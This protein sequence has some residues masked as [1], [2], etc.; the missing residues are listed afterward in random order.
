MAEYIEREAVETML[1]NAQII[2]DKEYCGYCTEDVNLDSIPAAD[3]VEVRHGRWIHLSKG[4]SCSE[5]GYQ[6]GRYESGK[7]YCPNCGAPMTDEAVEMV[8]EKLKKVVEYEVGQS[9]KLP[10]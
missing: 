7:N 4:D 9:C 8:M 6:T 3:V 5:C 2:T 10:K 1:E